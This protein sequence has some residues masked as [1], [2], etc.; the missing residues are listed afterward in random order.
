MRSASNALCLNVL[1]VIVLRMTVIT[2]MQII[3]LPE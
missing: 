3:A 2:T 1:I